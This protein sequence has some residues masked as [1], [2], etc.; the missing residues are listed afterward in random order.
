M[1]IIITEVQLNELNRQSEIYLNYLLDKISQSGWESLT[2]D[3]KEAMNKMSKDENAIDPKKK[4]DIKTIATLFKSLFP[5]KFNI[6][7]N[8]EN[9]EVKLSKTDETQTHLMVVNTIKQIHFLVIPFAEHQ[10]I[11]RVVVRGERFDGRIEENMP[12]T[13]QEVEEFYHE[14]VENGLPS[15]IETIDD[16]FES[17][18]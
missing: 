11:M 6:V 4:I 17:I 18:A 1:K 13:K 9:W 5:D 12:K 10:P 3:E 8:N 14:F 7:V 2:N 16:S 15:L